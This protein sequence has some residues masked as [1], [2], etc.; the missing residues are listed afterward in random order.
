[1]PF[2]RS[3]LDILLVHENPEFQMGQS[4]VTEWLSGF[5]DRGFVD[6]IG[7]PTQKGEVYFGVKNFR[8]L[9]VWSA[10][11]VELF[12][13]HQGG[14]RVLCP[15]AFDIIT[16]SF[17]ETITRWRNQG[18]SL[19]DMIMRGCPACQASHAFVDLVGR[20]RFAFGMGALR[21][22]DASNV[23][24]HSP[25]LLEF[26]QRFGNVHIVLKRVG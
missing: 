20:P 6:E 22:V 13:N 25:F 17:V 12:A 18:S 21:F 23:L 3:Q 11:S 10:N 19:D 4:T 7:R 15:K 16:S 24:E 5:C 26:Q 14:Y 1:M 2:P 9:D 8:S